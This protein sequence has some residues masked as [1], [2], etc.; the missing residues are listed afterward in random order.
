MSFSDQEMEAREW[1]SDERA[2]LK[3][4]RIARVRGDASVIIDA[5]RAKAAFCR[6]QAR[7]VRSPMLGHNGGPVL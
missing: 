2:F 5:W 1:E 4:G 6:M 3:R 7:R